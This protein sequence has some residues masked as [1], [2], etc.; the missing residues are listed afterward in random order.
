MLPA[1]RTMLTLPDDATANVTL[2][3]NGERIEVTEV[4][5]I[6]VSN[7]QRV[8]A[9]IST[10]WDSP[11]MIEGD[12]VPQYWANVGLPYGTEMTFASPT[13]GYVYPATA[14]LHLA[15]VVTVDCPAWR[16]MDA[17][18]A[19]AAQGPLGTRLDDLLAAAFTS[20]SLTMGETIAVRAAV[21]FIMSDGTAAVVDKFSRRYG[22]VASLALRTADGREVI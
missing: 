19:R 8:D 10:E 17:A 2:I 6:Y 11:Y 5:A 20:G 22:R 16:E 15:A 7:G 18:A 21:D 4:P 3:W 12:A 13:T 9:P 1:F 14:A